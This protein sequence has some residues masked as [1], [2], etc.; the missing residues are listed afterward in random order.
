MTYMVSVCGSNA[1]RKEHEFLIDAKVEAQRL[2]E[3]P[4]NKDRVIHVVQIVATLAPVTKH[5]W[6]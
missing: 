1:P 5:E 6:R 4:N 2:A 3:Q